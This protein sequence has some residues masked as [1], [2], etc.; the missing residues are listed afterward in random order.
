[1][2]DVETEGLLD[3]GSFLL[4]AGTL[5]GNG[6]CAASL[7]LGRHINGDLDGAYMAGQIIASQIHTVEFITAP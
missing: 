1:M 2:D 4:P 5:T 6:S 7:T 3:A